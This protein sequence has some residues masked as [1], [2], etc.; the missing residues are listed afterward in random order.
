[1]ET[2]VFKGS[3]SSIQRTKVP[4]AGQVTWMDE[5]N[6]PKAERD[7]RASIFGVASGILG[8]CVDR[9]GAWWKARNRASDQ[10]NR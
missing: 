4:E 3:P 2:S 7:C 6:E 10:L 9:E 1:M 5:E 8:S